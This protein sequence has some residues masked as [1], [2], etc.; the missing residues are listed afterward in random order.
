MPDLFQMIINNLSEGSVSF[1]VDPKGFAPVEGSLPRRSWSG[2]SIPFAEE[3]AIRFDDEVTVSTSAPS[4][5][6]SFDGETASVTK[7]VESF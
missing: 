4:A 2:I 6:V 1:M 7:P 5:L 3:Y